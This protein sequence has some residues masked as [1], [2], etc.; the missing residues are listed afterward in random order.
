M[1]IVK[2]RDY[3]AQLLG[4]PV[5]PKKVIATKFSTQVPDADL[6]LLQHPR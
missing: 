5:G 3:R 6:G 1:I 4:K 2:A